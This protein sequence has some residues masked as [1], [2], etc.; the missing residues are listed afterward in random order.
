MRELGR[1]GMQLTRV[2]F[3][4][5][6][7][8]GGGTRFGWGSQDDRDSVEAI[9]HAVELGV[10]W[11]D[12]APAY[13]MGHSEEIVGAA[14]RELAPSDRPFVFTK[15]G[16]V[17]DAEDPES[18][19][20]NVMAADSVRAELEQS[21]RRLGVETID[22]YQV[23]W[24]PTDG[25]RL[26]D[27]WA[28]MVALR[29]EGKV[30]AIGISNHDEA[31][32]DRA[33]S[34]GHVDS[35]QPPLSLV[36]REAARDVLPW[37]AAHGTGVIVYSP[38]QSG[39]LTGAMSTERAASLPADDWRRNDGEFSGAALERNLHLVEALRPVA[40]RHDV[41]L[42]SVAAAWTLDWPQV[43]GAIIGARRAAQVDDWIDA[44]SVQL[45]AEDHDE[46]AN[47]LAVTGAGSGPV[48]T[49]WAA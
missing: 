21:L 48:R 38:L 34:V 29:D 12:T 10:N 35:I 37:A 7:L 13:G 14:L 40:R 11:I 20:R 4:A 46:I 25:T 45:T 31:Q 17:F 23:H 39:L 6:A 42:A 3:G 5:W 16:L 47:A 41:S 22:L 9:K 2:G 49:T 18:G 44:G 43:T 24:P 27:Y 28:T 19:P 32:L 26:E 8:G 36:R 1:T 33:E 30:R 15:C